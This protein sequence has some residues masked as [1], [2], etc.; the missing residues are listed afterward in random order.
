M[1]RVKKL[2]RFLNITV[3]RSPWICFALFFIRRVSPFRSEDTAGHD[4]K[5]GA[6]APAPQLPGGRVG[7][8][9]ADAGAVFGGA[10]VLFTNAPRGV[11]IENVPGGALTENVPGGPSGG[12]AT[13]TSVTM[14]SF[15]DGM[16]ATGTPEVATG[17]RDTFL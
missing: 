15:K 14:S 16:G 9:E 7:A 1:S 11:S 17:L 8:V 4:S 3:V 2:G 12:V 5:F 6:T 13:F 10:Q